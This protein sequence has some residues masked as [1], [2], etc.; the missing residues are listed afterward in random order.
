MTTVDNFNA[1][2]FGAGDPGLVNVAGAAIDHNTTESAIDLRVVNR[3]G[4]FADDARFKRI[5]NFQS[6]DRHVRIGTIDFQA[7]AP[8][9][10]AVDYRLVAVRRG[11][12]HA[13]G[14]YAVA[15]QTL[16][17]PG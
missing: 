4:A 9:A 14:K 11:Q 1:K 8:Q 2:D 5:D 6:R 13:P 16:V 10:I 3:Q 12:T 15:T 7:H 17:G